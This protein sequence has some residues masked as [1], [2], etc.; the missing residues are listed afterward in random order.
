MV[1]DEGI[2]FD[3]NCDK[4]IN[5]NCTVCKKGYLLVLDGVCHKK[6]I[7]CEL[8]NGVDS[9]KCLKCLA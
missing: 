8:T 9:M 1:N 5:G 6:A 7:G 4:I 3:V 2:C